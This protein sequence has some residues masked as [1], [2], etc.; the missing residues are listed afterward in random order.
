MTEF[1]PLKIQIISFKEEHFIAERNSV[2]Q[3]DWATLNVSSCLDI[4]LFTA[5]L[6]DCVFMEQML[7][8]LHAS[9]F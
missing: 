8:Q 7:H 2:K 6:S 3:I 9:D 5:L 1:S 4:S